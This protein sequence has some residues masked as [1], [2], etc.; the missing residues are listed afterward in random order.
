[1]SS[2]RRWLVTMIVGLI[3][4]LLAA[5]DFNL[6]VGKHEVLQSKVLGE[7]RDILVSVPAQP[8]PNM[9]LLIVLDGEW[10]F[11][12]V[13]VIVD[14]LVGNG[15]LPPMVVAGHRQY[16]PRPGFHSYV[17]RQRLCGRT[18][19]SFP[20]VYRRRTDSTPCRRSIR[21][22]S[23]IFSRDTRMAACFHSMR[24]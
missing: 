4:P 13:A 6:T 14:H 8:K 9:P 18:I 20:L 5:Q 15:R 3:A 11:T 19:G 7:K 17:R 10:T 12:K 24:S 22:A 2:I 1:M 23:T 21:S 16:R